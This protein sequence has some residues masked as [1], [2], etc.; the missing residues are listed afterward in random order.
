MVDDDEEL[1]EGDDDDEGLET[2]TDEGDGGQDSEEGSQGGEEPEG[3]ETGEEHEQ[4]LPEGR[5]DSV[6]PGKQSRSSRRYQELA[7]ARREAEEKATAAELRAR[8]LEE[9]YQREEA[10]RLQQQQQAEQEAVSRLTPEERNARQFEQIQAQI[11]YQEQMRVFDKAE[12]ED[13][14]KFDANASVNPVYKNAVSDVEKALTDLRKMNINMSR[15]AILRY[16]LGDRMLKQT[17]K[18]KQTQAPKPVRKVQ[19]APNSRGDVSSTQ[20]KRQSTSEKQR[21]LD[22][23]GETPI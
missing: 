12:A 16:V 1:I 14:A 9:R 22:T 2:E 15:E 8:A 17:Q 19:K 4:P 23:W 11:R 21:I 10:L 13:K 5:A 18:S 3:G 20:G 7:N 6:E